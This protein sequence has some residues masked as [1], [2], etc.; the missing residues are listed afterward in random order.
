VRRLGLWMR[1]ELSIRFDLRLWRTNNGP[2]TVTYSSRS[3]I[4]GSR[5]F[6]VVLAVAAW[7][8]SRLVCPVPDEAANTSSTVASE[9]NEATTSKHDDSD[10]CCQLLGNAHAIAEPLVLFAAVKMVPLLLLGFVVTLLLAA[11][12][13]P[14]FKLI[15]VANSPPR[16]RYQRFTTFWPHAPPADRT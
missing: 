7:F 1:A 16:S 11:A 9:R 8:I 5:R 6:I 3:R 13:D 15:P 2:V 12:T 14:V 4:S 10:L